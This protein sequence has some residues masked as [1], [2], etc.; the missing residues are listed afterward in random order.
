M[1][2][3]PPRIEPGAE[4]DQH[5][6]VGGD[7]DLDPIVADRRHPNLTLALLDARELAVPLLDG[8]DVE[9]AD[10]EFAVWIAERRRAIDADDPLDV[11]AGEAR[12]RQVLDAFA[13]EQIG[14]PG[15]V[16]RGQAGLGGEVEVL[17]GVELE[18]RAPVGLGRHPLHLAARPRREKLPAA[19][20]GGEHQRL[21]VG[22]GR[23]RAPE[24]G[25]HPER[26]QR[27]HADDTGGDQL[28]R[29]SGIAPRGDRRAHHDRDPVRGDRTE[30]RTRDLREALGT[31]A[32]HALP[33]RQIERE[34]RHVAE[35]DEE[36]QRDRRQVDDRRLARPQPRDDP[37][38]A[39][40]RHHRERARR[41]RMREQILEQARR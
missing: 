2:R 36:H 27:Q 4:R 39:G 16:E 32:R 6:C 26:G 38:V 17:V 30:E 33:R 9:R 13:Q 22:L 20:I 3:A 34:V 8:A 23:D 31:E 5:R 14:L 29:R 1:L 37:E 40:V 15:Q 11:E 19:R 21:V 12:R 28:L 24:R 25:Q 18:Q 7:V 41:C 35:P 10:R